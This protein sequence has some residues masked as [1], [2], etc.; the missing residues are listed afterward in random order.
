MSEALVAVLD[1]GFDDLGLHRIEAACLPSNEASQG[2]LQKVGFSEEGYARQY[3]RINA[4]WQD[5][6]LFAV[7]RDD[8]RPRSAAAEGWSG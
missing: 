7:L 8:K 3:L 2:L 1:Y 5:H 6:R 4:Q